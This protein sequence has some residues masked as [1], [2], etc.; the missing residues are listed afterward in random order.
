MYQQS[1]R[2]K[3]DTDRR[4]SGLS[5]SSDG[6]RTIQLRGDVHRSNYIQ[7]EERTEQLLAL[8][9][10]MCAAYLRSG[11]VI[12]YLMPAPPMVPVPQLTGPPVQ[13]EGQTAEEFQLLMEQHHAAVND[14]P[15]QV[16]TVVNAVNV[17]KNGKIP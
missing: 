14:H 4:S 1:K 8:D 15:Q 10:N 17:A 5:R 12:E 13:A 9:G 3:T 2:L 7:W 16:A 6:E 11:D